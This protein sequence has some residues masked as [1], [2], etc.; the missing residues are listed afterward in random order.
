MK[1]DN[2]KKICRSVLELEERAFKRPL[3]FVSFTPPQLE[4]LKCTQKYFILRGGNQIG[5]SFVGSAEVIYRASSHPTDKSRSLHPFKKTPPPPISIWIVCHSWSQS[6]EMQ[7]R[8]WN[9][10]AKDDL[11]EGTEYIGGKGFRGAG[12]PVVRWKNGSVVKFKTTQQ[13]GGGKGT[14]ALASGTVDF[15][16][17]DEPPPAN[18]WSELVARTLRRKGSALACTF[19]PVGVPVDYLKKMVDEGLVKDIHAPLTVQNVQPVGCKRSLL[20]DQEIEEIS[21]SYLNFDR[22]CRME[23]S[24]E[25][26][27]PDG[28][29]FEHFR[30][31]L[32][33]DVDPRRSK[34]MD[35]GTWKTSV[36]IDH[37]SAA[38]SEF[39]VLAAIWIP[40]DNTIKPYIYILDEYYSG[41]ATA[42][43]H[44]RGILAMLRRNRLDHKMVDRWTGDRSH[45]GDK[46]GGRM[47]NTM[48]RAAFEHVLNYP[49]GR[50]FYIHTAYKPSYSVYY[51]SRVLSELQGLS[52]F[53]VHPRCKS[54]I[55]SFKNWAILKNG[56]MDRDSE[57]KHAIDSTR[58]ACMCW[59]DATYR[60][61]KNS[62]IQ[63]IR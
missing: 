26:F 25:G 8:V 28:I 59:L 19:T 31:E 56:R 40:R 13:T 12:T 43:V 34:G 42:D 45:R 14:V 9:L 23:G 2:L 1:L 57:H 5:K 47:S 48:L 32:I 7:E 35:R 55:K 21:R 36:G 10:V 51:G 29:V 52:R 60:T 58:Y 30:D 62:K 22:S 16:L 63:I 27:T 49:R 18:V 46:Y 24:W 4:F 54:L 38:G 61:P 3:D 6:V 37:G 53:Q 33:S 44:A 50:G 39:A 20:T 15:V 11:E 41:A 17:I